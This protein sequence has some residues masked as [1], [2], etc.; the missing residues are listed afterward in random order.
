MELC[1]QLLHFRQEHDEILRFLREWETA[2]Q[3]AASA[4]DADRREGLTRLRHMEKTLLAIG[5]HCRAEEESVESPYNLYLEDS[6]LQHL[7]EG[8]EL[9]TQA[10][11]NYL[12]EL[13]FATTL[14]TNELV[15]LGQRLLEQLRH[16]IAFEEGLLKQIEDGRA[17]EE[18]RLLQYT[19]AAE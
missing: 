4:A 5:E 18:K 17:A 6:E 2:L 11:Q 16:H 15:A 9:L 12:R 3:F 14:R 19:H 1:N 13:T 10:T 8:H 7:Q